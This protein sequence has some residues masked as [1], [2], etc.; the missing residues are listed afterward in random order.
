MIDKGQVYFILLF[1]E[2]IIV[3]FLLRSNIYSFYISY[4][5]FIDAFKI[6]I[7]YYLNR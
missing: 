2:K 1:T 3:S 5:M 4:L 6:F 7:E